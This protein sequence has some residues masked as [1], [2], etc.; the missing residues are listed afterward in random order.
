[1]LPVVLALALTLPPQEPKPVSYPESKKGDV[2]AAKMILERA[3]GP[4]AEALDV[5]IRLT[6]LENQLPNSDQK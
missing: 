6:D 2:A 4:A 1:M 5:E 3:L